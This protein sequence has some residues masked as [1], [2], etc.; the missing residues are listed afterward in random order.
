MNFILSLCRIDEISMTL[1]FFI[2]ACH[3]ELYIF[4]FLFR[5]KILATKTVTYIDI[6]IYAIEE[7]TPSFTKGAKYSSPL[8]P[9]HL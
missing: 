3:E 5:K 8:Y 2:D 9:H 4:P 6:H 7:N 1:L